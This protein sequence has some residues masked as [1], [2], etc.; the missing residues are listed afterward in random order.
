MTI[1]TSPPAPRHRAR[2]VLLV[3]GCT[4]LA[5]LV[6]FLTRP[7][8]GPL[9]ASATGDQELAALARDVGGED[10]TALAIA[11]VTPSSTRSAVIGA[12]TDDR[13]EIGSISK[14][15]TG[16]LFADM[17]TRGEVM[18]DQ[19]LGSLLDI[20]GPLADITLEQLATHRS[21]LPKL[22][23]TPADAVRAYWAVITAGNPY[24]QTVE[25]EIRAAEQ[26]KLTAPPGTYSNIGFE[27]L[28]AALAA[29]AD[30]PYPELLRERIL[31]PLSMNDTT[32]PIS[33]D[34]LTDRDLIGETAGG[35]RAEPWLGEAIA[36]AGGVRSDITD[37]AA[38]AQALLGRSAP[39]S[40]ALEPK[41]RFDDEQV[42]WA[43]ITTRD[44]DSGRTVVWHNGGTGGFASFLGL[45]SDTDTA[46]VVLS[47]AASSPSDIARDGFVLLAQLKG[48]RS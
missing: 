20:S 16:L 26:A 41:A 35:R 7:A 10:S 14:G 42:G 33:S 17:I 27:L 3:V 37:M 46:V 29:A 31:R 9:P 23:L 34:Q 25:Q 30:R 5:L 48:C 40:D 39:G 45:D 4:A 32:A 1:S 8:A 44:P 24:R 2:T 43:W 36:P 38:L 47:A 13:F 19:K 28:G 6:G 21:G 15:L 18:P 22:A 11:C 12:G